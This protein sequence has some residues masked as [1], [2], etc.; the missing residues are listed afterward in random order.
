[1]NLYV[2]IFFLQCQSVKDPTELNFA[3][4]SVC[5][6]IV[7]HMAI[8]RM[9]HAIVNQFHEYLDPSKFVVV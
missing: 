2:F 4:M 1:M 8:V 3:M 6:H 9:D 5:V 7:G